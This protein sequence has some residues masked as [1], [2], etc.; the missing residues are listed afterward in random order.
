MRMLLVYA[1]SLFC[2]SCVSCN[3]SH[4]EEG[5]DKKTET[6]DYFEYSNPQ[7]FTGIDNG[8]ML[9][10]PC[11]VKEGDTYYLTGTSWPNF[12]NYG[13][14]PGT[15]IYAS[16]DLKNWRHICDPVRRPSKEGPEWWKCNFWAPEIFIHNGKYYY[17]VNTSRTYL[18][19]EGGMENEVALFV[20]DKIG[21][22]YQPVTKEHSVTIGNDAHIFCD[23][24]GKIYMFVSGIYGF[25]IDLETGTQIGEKFFCVSP[26]SD[27]GKWTS[28][29][30]TGFEGP[31]VVLR[32][33]VYFLF[34][35]T[36]ARGYEIGYATATNIRGPWTMHPFPIYGSMNKAT[37]DRLGTKYE[38]DYYVNDF[39]ESGH[40]TIFKGP[41][42]R[43]WI[44]AHVFAE[45][46]TGGYLD[47]KV[48]MAFDPIE[49][50]N[51]QIKILD[52]TKSVNGPTKGTKRIKLK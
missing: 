25:E 31:Y 14:L 17:T 40:N 24:D 44:V 43:D 20:A 2:L 29:H 12:E 21:G 47:N 49:F 41:D 46:F 9:R 10:D 22:P 3:K 34:F 18:T 38:Q 35:S 32:D 52:G 19:D 23:I 1:I 15:S 39:A 6:G 13:E 28:V 42:G 50:D 5:D 37:C 26:T 16:E 4:D 45:P 48:G 7:R 27:Q 11:I 8:R 36:W 30:A 33:G 51:G